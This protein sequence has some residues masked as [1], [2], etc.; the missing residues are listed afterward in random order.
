M[1]HRAIIFDLDGTLLNTLDDIAISANRVLNNHGYP[2]HNTNRYKKFVGN[3][4]EALVRK[5]L[6]ANIDDES[7]VK[8]CLSELIEIYS[9]S[10][11]RTTDL[12]P[13]IKEM[14]NSLQDKRIRLSVFSNKPH[15]FTTAHVEHFLSDWNFE[16]VL[17]VKEGIPAKP[18]PFAALEIAKIMSI[19]VN[20]FIYAGDTSTD[21]KTAAGAKMFSAGVLWGFRDE[22]ELRESG[23]KAIISSPEE[24]LKLL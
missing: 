13:G 6:P 9:K 16:V 8:Q 18:D 3:G 23:A 22:N 4:M 15:E 17:G 21:M 1:K 2:L 7:I 24:L 11:H 10:W 14:L 12:Y 19:P 20:E 5:I